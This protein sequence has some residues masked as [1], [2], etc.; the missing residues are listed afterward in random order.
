MTETPKS[1]KVAKQAAR[2]SERDHGRIAN[3][4]V[5]V[6]DMDTLR[7]LVAAVASERQHHVQAELHAR[8]QQSLDSFRTEIENTIEAGHAET[9][10]PLDARQKAWSA[11]HDR[12]EGMI[13]SLRSETSTGIEALE[14]KMRTM[15]SALANRIDERDKASDSRHELLLEAI[16]S[17][18]TDMNSMRRVFGVAMAL[19]VLPLALL[20]TEFLPD[21]RDEPGQPAPPPVD[22]CQS[23]DPASAREPGSEGTASATLP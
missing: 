14:T 22:A 15:V 1:A 23:Q 16:R 17:L 5:P 9:R 11:R 10:R 21:S 2:V 19:L 3:Q 8:I 18:R 7:I 4:A 12:L 13:T 6:L 20:A